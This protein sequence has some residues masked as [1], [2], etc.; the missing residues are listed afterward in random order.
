MNRPPS[1]KER[2][3]RWAVAALCLYGTFQFI[4]NPY[5]MADMARISWWTH[6]PTLALSILI[7]GFGL[8]LGM[9]FLRAEPPPPRL[10]R[11][12]FF[13]ACLFLV[14]QT[15]ATVVPAPYACGC[16][17]IMDSLAKISDWSRALYAAAL[18]FAVVVYLK[19]TGDGVAQAGKD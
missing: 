4:G 9:E 14:A 7:S 17:S 13:F 3:A 1:R 12:L 5:P 19:W 16:A 8:T 6:Y 18:L 10:R 11:A 2:I 15:L